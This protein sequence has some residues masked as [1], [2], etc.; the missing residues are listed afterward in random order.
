[1][2]R[3]R[4]LAALTAVV[5]VGGASVT[6]AVAGP[7]GPREPPNSKHFSADLNGFNEV[8]SVSSTGFGHF[9]AKLVD[10]TTLHFVFTYGGLE[11]GAS[12][13]AHVHFGGR[14]VNGGVSY[15]LCGPPANAPVTC[16]DVEGTIEGDITPA[17]VIG[18]NGQG[19]EPGSF[20]E[21]IRGMQA[22]H[23]YANIHTTRWGGGEIRGQI[24]DNDGN[25]F[26]G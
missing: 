1:M 23:A 26:D 5:L 20:A 21:I 6:Y 17:N 7:S 24:N 16:P 11:G 10:D 25:E 3:R 4:W 12:L 8:P 19:I 18:P 9:E 15:F 14:Y 2:T 22:G 13:F